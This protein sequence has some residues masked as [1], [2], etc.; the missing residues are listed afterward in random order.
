M[1]SLILT[2]LCIIWT[3]NSSF[4]NDILR[5]N[6]GQF[7]WLQVCLFARWYQVTD[8]AFYLHLWELT[9]KQKIECEQ[10]IAANNQT[11]KYA[12]AMHP[13][14]KQKIECEQLQQTKKLNDK[15]NQ[16]MHYLKPNG[17]TLI[18][19]HKVC[20]KIKIPFF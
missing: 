8:F 4:Q 2:I 16:L 9:N 7:H 19:H 3:D 10:I 12:T 14:N 13:V 6:S 5:L 17:S 1:Q 11:Q 15:N 20:Q 18:I